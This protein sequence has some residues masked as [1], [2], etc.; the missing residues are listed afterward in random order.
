MLEGIGVWKFLCTADERGA[1][2]LGRSSEYLIK[3]DIEIPM[4]QPPCFL[5]TYLKKFSH[6]LRCTSMKIL[7]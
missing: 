6:S 7:S 2:I 1:A 5:C 3:L 4:T